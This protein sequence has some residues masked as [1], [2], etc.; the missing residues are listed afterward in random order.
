MSIYLGFVVYPDFDLKIELFILCQ[1]IAYDYEGLSEWE[2]RD[3]R[4]GQD[5]G[6]V[7]MWGY[8]TTDSRSSSLLLMLEKEYVTHI[9]TQGTFTDVCVFTPEGKTVRTKVPS[10]SHDQSIGVKNGIL[11]AREELKS[12]YGW[13]GQFES[14][15]HGTTV[16]EPYISLSLCPGGGVCLLTIAWMSRCSNGSTYTHHRYQCSPRR[17]RRPNSPHRHSRPQ[18]C[19]LRSTLPDSGRTGRMDQFYPAS[20]HRPSRK[21]RTVSRND[22]FHR[23]NRHTGQ[24]GAT[25]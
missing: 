9:V 11:K 17:Q 18:R 25:P 19:P 22:V 2:T 5:I 13:E 21:Y 23:R 14:I 3:R 1:R 6:L 12:L 4:K 8:V 15:H 24:R 16:G 10:T 7:W 20:T